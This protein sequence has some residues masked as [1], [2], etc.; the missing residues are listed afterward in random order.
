MAKV[1]DHKLEI[2]TVDMDWV[3]RMEDRLAALWHEFV[4]RHGREPSMPPVDVEWSG[5]EKK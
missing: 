2:P 4:G 1:P 3:R 5:E